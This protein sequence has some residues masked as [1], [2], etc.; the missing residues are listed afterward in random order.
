M[1]LGSLV[2][3]VHAADAIRTPIP[4][5]LPTIP[6]RVIT[7][8]VLRHKPIF[9]PIIAEKFQLKETNSLGKNAKIPNDAKE[10]SKQEFKQ[11]HDSGQLILSSPK[12]KESRMGLEETTHRENIQYVKKALGNNLQIL[13]RLTR[14]A[15]DVRNNGKNYVH[16]IVDNKGVEQQVETM[17]E[18]FTYAELANTLKQ[19]PNKNNMINLYNLLYSKLPKKYLSSARIKTPKDL[20]NESPTVIT[21]TINSLVANTSIIGKYI[22]TL[23]LPPSSRPKSCSAEIGA[24]NSSSTMGD[25]TGNSC[26]PHPD[27]IFNN[28]RYPMKWYATCVKNQGSRGTC[29][30]F[31]ATSAVETAY[32]VN[33]NKWYNFSEQNL[34]NAAKMKWYPST[35]GDGLNT[36]GIMQ[37]LVNRN[38]KFGYEFAW[39]Y[40]PSYS[41]V[42]NDTNKNYTKSCNNYSGEH[43]SDTNHQG[44]KV[45][46]K[47]LWFT[48]C[49]YVE[50]TAETSLEI[51]GVAQ[52]WNPLNTNASVETA[53]L[54]SALKLPM[55]MSIPVTPSFDNAG[56]NGYAS[57]LGNNETSR[58]GHAVAVLGVVENSKLPASAPAGA[59][60]GYFIVKNS[61]GACWKDAGYIY[62]PISWVKAYA[63]SLTVVTSI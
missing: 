20:E 14:K 1:I 35:Y 33:T 31:A 9:T 40:N 5:R 36:S 60:G 32:A 7:G 55:V 28:V 17:G 62:L 6:G 37:D 2:Y 29:V 12:I 26:S 27:G 30:S 53:K 3:T 56:V 38:Y 63:K 13:E 52:I 59:G 61:W 58:G 23:D 16:T 51:D 25:Q 18:E 42:K 11:L 21:A 15:T 47:I 45:C 8:P 46:T 10:V 48:Y 39:D 43:C 24:A 34:Y 19:F 57:Y 50:Q 44:K 41:R 22:T 49:G 54:A 4:R